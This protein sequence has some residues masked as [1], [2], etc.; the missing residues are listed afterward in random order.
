MITAFKPGQRFL[1]EA[2]PELGLGL[3]SDV[4]SRQIELIFPLAEETR[5]YVIDNA[6]LLRLQLNPGDTAQSVH[7]W[8]MHVA[9]VSV[10]DQLF[11]YTGTRAD[12]GDAVELPEPLLSAQC[13]LNQ[14]RE[15]LLAGQTGHNRDFE[16]RLD[17]LQR[18]ATAHRSAHYGL[19]GPRVS[20]L[21]H[22]L[23]VADQVSRR[24]HPRVLLA[25]EV[26]LGKTIEAGMIVHRQLLT[27]RATR[28][29][30][31]VPDA[32]KHQWLIE[33][34]RRFNL[35]FTLVTSESVD[36]FDEAQ[37]LLCPL[38]LLV[39]DEALG[40]AALMAEWD[41]LVV[42][43]AHHLDWSRDATSPAYD[44]V[45]ALARE[46][47]S[48]LLLTATPEQLGR[49]GHFARLRLLDP[50]R[51]HDLDAHLA[52]EDAHRAVAA[53]AEPLWHAD[54]ALTPEQHSALAPYIDDDASRALL[55]Q[56][57]DD[58]AR[59][60][61]LNHLIDH[62][63]TGRV[64]FRN[65]RSAV[66]GLPK[67]SVQHHSLPTD[68]ALSVE[69]ARTK[70][71][72]DTLKARPDKRFL[73]ICAEDDTALDIAT[74]LRLKAGIVAAVFHGGMSILECDRAAAH[75]ADED[76]GCPILISSEIGSE[77]RNFQFVNELI[78]FDLP[79]QPDLLEQRI[80]RVDRIGQDRDVIVHVPTRAG[81][82]DDILRRWY[83]E[84]LGAFS[85]SCNYGSAVLQQ[86]NAAREHALNNPGD[87]TALENLLTDTQRITADVRAT[88][89]AGRDRLLELASTDPIESSA[90]ALEL[91]QMDEQ[92]GPW[93]FIE[94]AADSFG[95][96]LEELSAD[97]Y[98]I[99]IGS[100]AEQQDFPG[101]P[102]DGCSGTDSRE[103][104]LHREDLEFIT[105]EHP[106]VRGLLHMV[107]DGDTGKTAAAALQAQPFKPGE[108][109]IETV[110]SM[111]SAV[112]G[113]RWQRHLPTTWQRLLHT[114][115]GL[116]IS[117]KVPS[118][119]L[120]MNV[121]NLDRGTARKLITAQRDGLS[122]R[123]LSIET[124]AK[125]R[126]KPIA[127]TARDNAN[128]LLGAEL[129]RLQALAARG[130]P[131]REEE[132]AALTQERDNIIASLEHLTPQLEAVR[133]IFT[134]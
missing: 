32:L 103:V 100:S 93:P 115:S 46:T 87:A 86:V 36:P 40:D 22:Q 68:D 130:A 76:S 56:P 30:I 48:V 45:D 31:L 53:A 50:D 20:L 67:R 38:S 65:T 96:E 34:R 97:S 119:W 42:D 101:L 18:L 37:C 60:T 51:F 14:P 105:W 41:M 4:E 73:L 112:P 133:V 121:K 107:V 126:I 64:L 24:H 102:E 77:G 28:V 84:G 108:V 127:D 99:H 116:E 21:P 79:D 8:E 49:E 15:R 5:R 17:S 27:G 71:L 83:D 61:L 2:E 9:S 44:L 89:E 70:W 125:A 29:L 88:L 134:H 12:T 7:G 123:L 98:S 16:L 33:L 19:H 13:S 35:S 54:T 6:P 110:F 63:G 109:L 111:Q 62:H 3:V 78:L 80:G 106:L 113:R 124:D 52:S 82:R 75:F 122:E 47:N 39:E 132:I 90:L 129:D 43:E 117:S 95:L 114:R 104:A 120:A 10:R 94:R 57:L 128:N 69:D 74:E 92:P 59:R 55:S 1:S 58:T 66:G 91:S 25:D 118:N 11:V 72:L 131:V 81:D 26:G 85:Q 23:Y